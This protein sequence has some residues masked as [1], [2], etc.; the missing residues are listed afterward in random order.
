MNM[1]IV[2]LESVPIR[3]TFL[4]QKYRPPGARVNECSI[5]NNF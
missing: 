1:I 4:I 5:L 2:K 3:I